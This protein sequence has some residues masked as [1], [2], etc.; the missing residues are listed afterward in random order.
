MLSVGSRKDWD[1]YLQKCFGKVTSAPSSSVVIKEIIESLTDSGS[2]NSR[3]GQ[4]LPTIEGFTPLVLALPAVAEPASLSVQ[5][6]IAIVPAIRGFDP[7]ILSKPT[8]RVFGVS[9]LKALEAIL[10]SLVVINPKTFSIAPNLQTQEGVIIRLPKLFPYKD[11]HRV[12]WKYVC[13]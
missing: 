2:S 4:T 6:G 13:P 1:E 11:S 8:S 10:P 9:G 3:K 12:P 7:L 5:E